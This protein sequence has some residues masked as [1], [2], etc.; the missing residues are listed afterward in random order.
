MGNSQNTDAILMLDDELDIVNIFTRA[1]Q[2]QGFCVIGFTKPMLALDH[3][4]KNFDLYSL[5]ISDIR[6]PVMDGYEFIKRVK[7]IK[8]DVKVFFMAAYLSDDI[9][10]R[11]GLPSVTVDEYIEKPIS[12]NHFISLVKKYF[13]TTGAGA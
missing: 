1:L 11:T 8:R 10:Y 2:Q 7:E 9:Q 4:Q 6:M 3:F 5:V 13:L 12:I